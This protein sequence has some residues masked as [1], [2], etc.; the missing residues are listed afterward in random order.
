MRLIEQS[1]HGGNWWTTMLV[2]F[3]ALRSDIPVSLTTAKGYAPILPAALAARTE[4]P[5]AWDSSSWL[6]VQ[7]SYLRNEL[8]LRSIVRDG[9]PSLLAA[10][11][12][13]LV[14]APNVAQ[15]VHNPEPRPVM[16]SAALGRLRQRAVVGRSGVLVR[17]NRSFGRAGDGWWTWPHPVGP[18]SF[19]RR[20]VALDTV[21]PGM[22]EDGRI[23]LLVFGRSAHAE[24]LARLLGW[25]AELPTGR[26]RSFSLLVS[27]HAQLPPDLPH[28]LAVLR[29]H[30]PLAD[31]VL[32]SVLAQVDAVAV[33]YES[34]PSSVSGIMT[35]AAAHNCQ[36]VA[37]PALDPALAFPAPT[38]A[39]RGAE[40]LSALTA[41]SVPSPGDWSAHLDEWGDAFRRR[42]WE[43]SPLSEH[44]AAA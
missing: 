33:P 39:G 41:R 38:L 34:H 23:R 24:N 25:I 5:L 19:H 42:V 32:D 35:L 22:A 4:T 10:Q 18:A 20:D 21:F 11:A 44:R 1:G 40:G 17:H 9:E 6:A 27:G 37:G 26:R 2:G 3:A 43:R 15:F 14:V 29:H 28:G 13:G 8:R 7:R 31:D 16:R 36:I 12:T 30:G